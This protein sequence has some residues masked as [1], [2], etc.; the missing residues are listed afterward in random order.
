M[1]ENL[2]I[3]ATLQRLTR[4]FYTQ[5]GLQNFEDFSWAVIACILSNIL[6]IY[7]ILGLTIRQSEC[8]CNIVAN[9]I[10]VGNGWVPGDCREYPQIMYNPR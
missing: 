2:V 9:V 4:H 3:Y 1:K 10:C 7:L 8:S 5:V 6:G